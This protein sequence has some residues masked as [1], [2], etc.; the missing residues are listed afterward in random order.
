MAFHY[1]RVQ[2]AGVSLYLGTDTCRAHALS[3]AISPFQIA[4][5]FHLADSEQRLDGV[6]EEGEEEANGPLLDIEEAPLKKK[7]LMAEKKRRSG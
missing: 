7:D 2:L 1:V 4:E 5:P 3:T 6:Q